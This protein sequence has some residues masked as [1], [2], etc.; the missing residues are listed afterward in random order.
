MLGNADVHDT[1]S[2][3]TKEFGPEKISSRPSLQE[4]KLTPDRA[5]KYA[6]RLGFA[7][8]V[9]GDKVG[10]AFIKPF[11][12]QAHCPSY[13]FIMSP[14]IKEALLWWIEYLEVM[15]TMERH[16]N[17]ENLPEMTLWTDAAGAL[18]MCAALLWTGT[19]YVWTMD[20]C[21]SHIY[22]QFVDRRDDHILL[23]EALAIA[24]ANKTFEEILDNCNVTNFVD[25]DAVLFSMIKGTAQAADLRA[26]VGRVW[27]DMAVKRVAW[28]GFRV[29]SHSNIADSPTRDRW[30]IFGLL[31]AR[32]IPPQ[33]PGWLEVLWSPVLP[34]RVFKADQC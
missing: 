30:H 19:E 8:H 14:L 5:E 2:Q 6:G 34:T 7:T 16:M 11:F 33:W 3:K 27:M 15:P 24:L 29:E 18:T 10:R 28:Q 23:Q 32:F 12:M 4:G 22:S 17:D 21:P 20:K 13:D 25:N 9:M 26:V 1:V 31:G